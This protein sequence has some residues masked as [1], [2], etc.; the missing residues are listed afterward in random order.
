MAAQ[1]TQSLEELTELAR[2]DP[3]AA[4]RQISDLSEEI[5]SL[6]SAFSE[7]KASL[8]GEKAALLEAHAAL[9]EEKAAFAEQKVALFR[10]LA[11]LLEQLRQERAERFAASS[12]RNDLQYRLFD[13]SEVNAEEEAVDDEVVAVPAHERKVAKRKPLP[14]DLPRQVIE[15]APER[16]H[17]GCGSEL[18]R[19]G[20]KVSEQLDIIPEQLFVIEHRRGTWKCP[21][22]EDAVPETAPMPAQPIPK[23][24]ASP[25]LLAF[26]ATRKYADG[27]PLYRQSAAFGRLG[28]DLPR[29]T[30]A[31][32][33]ICIGELVEPLVDRLRRTALEH[34]VLQIDETRVQ[35]LKE[36]GRLA[37]SQSWMW[38]LNGGP[39]DRPVIHYH[40]DPSRSSAVP[41]ELLENFTGYLQSDGYAG[42]G[43][44]LERAEVR[45][46]GCWAHARRGFIKARK[47]LPSHKVSPK[48]EQILAW[49]QKLYALERAW[50]NLAPEERGKRRQEQARPVLDKIE[51][52]LAQQDPP[53]KSLLGKAVGYLR[54]EW[55]RLTV[56][57]EDG[58]LSIDNNRVENAIRPFAVGRKNWLFSDR[59][60]GARASAALYGLIETTK[61]NGLNPYAYLKLVLRELPAVCNDADLD[62]LLPW[63]VDP[64][65]LRKIMLPPPL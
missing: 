37:Q 63:N 51:V 44:V 54:S 43:A 29:Q 5:A 35:V 58:R 61:L 34:D 1:A 53:P 65:L 26:V 27:L 19:I 62:A 40:Y 8:L 22:C 21:C 30:L 39:P 45:G 41:V 36:E 10:K 46:L 23:S 64:E 16:T 31:R 14:K 48:L 47:A 25:G 49:I 24:N 17:C 55:P 60:E 13:E 15:H 7:E 4:A 42:Y 50:K 6:K 33:M 52:W 9:A 3:N 28:I 59:P 38:V 32:H 56:Y 11:E 20:T 18:I 12:E 57:V 2:R